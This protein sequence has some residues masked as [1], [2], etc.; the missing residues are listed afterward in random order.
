MEA[1]GI[2]E[3]RPDPQDRRALGVFLTPK[4][5]ELENLAT[6]TILKANKLVLENFS[7]EQITLLK[8]LLK[9]LGDRKD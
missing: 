2:I 1:K 5:Y 3:R 7:E 4:G 8:Q 9:E 6:D